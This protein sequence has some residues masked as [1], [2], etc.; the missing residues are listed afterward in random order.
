MNQESKDRA[1]KLLDPILSV[2]GGEDGGVAFAKL[3]HQFL[4]EI[5]DKAGTSVTVDEFI[6]MVHRFS[7][8][9]EQMLKGRI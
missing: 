4:P 7:G 3:R 9:C 8:L 1:G 5:L 2:F 6:L